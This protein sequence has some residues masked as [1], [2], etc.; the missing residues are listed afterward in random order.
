MLKKYKGLVIGS[1]WS[2]ATREEGNHADCYQTHSKCVLLGVMDISAE[3]AQKASLDHHCRYYPEIES[4]LKDNP[5]IVSLAIH[6][7]WRMEYLNK[8]C[9]HSSVKA[10]FCEKP[11]GSS[12]AEAIDIVKI[13]KKAGKFLYVNYQRRVNRTNQ[14]LKKEF[15]NRVRGNLQHVNFYIMRGMWTAASHY[16]DLGLMYFGKPDWV[17]AVESPIPSPYS[18]DKNATILLG[19][20]QFQIHIIPLLSWDKG[21]YTCDQ[22]FIFDKEK[23]YIPNVSFY[24]NEDVTHFKVEDHTLKRVSSDIKLHRDSSDYL[25]VLDQIVADLDK[26][27]TEECMDPM[28]SVWSVKILELANRSKEEMRRIDIPATLN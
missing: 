11:L 9:E 14:Q 21:F 5:D 24:Q 15:E 22:E 1:G 16:I 10:I 23:F 7:Q 28:K 8:I 20:P 17:F 13:C 3:K 6:P 26:E 2:G 27:A 19:Y 12:T 25:P 4:A 18:Y